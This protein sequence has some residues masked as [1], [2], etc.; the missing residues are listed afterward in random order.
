M[1]SEEEIK[2]DLH[3]F[4][5]LADALR[6]KY[7]P[8]FSCVIGAGVG[9]KD[10]EDDEEPESYS[11]I[12]CAEGTNSMLQQTCN[13]FFKSVGLIDSIIDS[14]EYIIVKDHREKNT[15]KYMD[16]MAIKALYALKIILTKTTDE[17]KR[18]EAEFDAEEVVKNLLRETGFITN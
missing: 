10:N 16:E 13:S 2:E 5:D 4:K 9:I 3:R 17:Y 12:V 7:G 18:A 6:V 8:D 14:I 1:Y 15:P 11:G